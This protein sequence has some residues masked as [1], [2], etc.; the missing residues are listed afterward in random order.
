M[1]A[2]VRFRVKARAWACD[3]NLGLDLGLGLNFDLN[4]G[5][6]FGLN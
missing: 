6:N 4:L 5:L 3:R 1:R 2:V